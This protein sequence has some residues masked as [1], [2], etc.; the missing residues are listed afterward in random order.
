MNTTLL[1]ENLFSHLN[2]KYISGSTM[3][4]EIGSWRL[5]YKLFH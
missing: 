2:N 4:E 1:E 3:M 5:F